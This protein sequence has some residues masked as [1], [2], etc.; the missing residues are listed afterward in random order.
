MSSDI[1]QAINETFGAGTPRTVT[2]HSSGAVSIVIRVAE[3]VVV[4]DGTAA[5]TEWGISIDPEDEAAF[6]GH[7]ETAASL[8]DALRTAHATIRG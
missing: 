8:A 4:I 6:S 2:V 7:P 5:H 1:D 3:H